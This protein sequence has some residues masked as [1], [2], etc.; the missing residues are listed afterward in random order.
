MSG[1]ILILREAEIREL[2][3]PAACIQAI[4]RAFSAYSSGRAE[5]PAVIHL[6]VPENRGEI[7]IKA[8]HLH[9]GA[10]YAVK[11]VSG[12]A[13]N[14]SLGLPANNGM[15]VVF[16]AATGAPAAFLLDN[17]FITDR[18]TGAAGAVAATFLAPP[19]IQ[20]V[21][22]LGTGGQVRHQL[23]MLAHVRSFRE[24]RIWGRDFTKAGRV[25][26]DLGRSFPRP[27]YRFA[28]TGS[29]EEAVAEADVVITV[30]A[31]RRPLLKPE[32]LK[33]GATVI[34]VGSDAPEKQ[35]LD[36]AVLARAD[37]IVADSISQCLR[38]GEIHH[39]VA[40]G[41]ISEDMVTELGDITAGRKPGRTSGGELIVCDLTGVGVQD[42]AAAC[43]IMERARAT[44]RGEKI[45][46]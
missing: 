3:D 10:Y 24:A 42:T 36:E 4:E 30:T 28:A 8:G 46:L 13:G 6:D 20:T 12:F 37:T 45:A 31:S 2:L 22:I 5:L 9:G 33:S 35:E 7:H 23:E 26:E 19:Q 44:H 14:P 16:D 32:W 43:L 18:R 39:A 40:H 21:A 1:E 17:G 41:A 29:V 11:I 15:V 25:A 38:L 34:A 27:G